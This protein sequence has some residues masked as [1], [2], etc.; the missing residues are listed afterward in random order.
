MCVCACVCVC[1]CVCLCVLLRGENPKRIVGGTD[2]QKSW[3]AGGTP[4]IFFPER[5]LRRKS[6]KSKYPTHITKISDK[7]KKK[8]KKKKAKKKKKKRS[9]SPTWKNVGGHVPP[10]P[11]GFASVTIVFH[12]LKASWQF[13]R[14]IQKVAPTGFASSHKTWQNSWFTKAKIW[15]NKQQK[16]HIFRFDMVSNTPTLREKNHMYKRSFSD[17]TIFD[18]D[19]SVGKAS[20]CDY[21][22]LFKIV[23][24]RSEWKHCGTLMSLLYNNVQYGSINSHEYKRFEIDAVDIKISMTEYH[25][26]MWKNEYGKS[27]TCL[28]SLLWST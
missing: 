15:L 10:S 26:W 22:C 14:W 12:C 27:V 16:E 7:Q 4:T 24:A 18:T 2:T 3:W 13:L 23:E 28:F 19:C 25:H 8:K 21:Y 1:V 6:R 17:C 20:S 5:H 9:L 11:P